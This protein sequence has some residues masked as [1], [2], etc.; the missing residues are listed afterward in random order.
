MSPAISLSVCLRWACWQRDGPG[1]SKGPAAV[2]VP[3]ALGLSRTFRSNIESRPRDVKADRM[4]VA[5]LSNSASSGEVR[6]GERAAGGL[7]AS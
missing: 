7:T 5:G 6:H 3:Y 2:E 1:G 4:I